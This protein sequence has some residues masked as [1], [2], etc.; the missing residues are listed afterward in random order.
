MIS[1]RKI[2]RLEVR[3]QE[4]PHR[5]RARA[6]FLSICYENDIISDDANFVEFAYEYKENP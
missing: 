6:F 5:E 4:S 2:H 1:N 3:R